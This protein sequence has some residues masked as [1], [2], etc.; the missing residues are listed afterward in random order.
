MGRRRNNPSKNE[1]QRRKREALQKALVHHATH[2]PTADTGA[3]LTEAIKG[4]EGLS[5]EK[6][7]IALLTLGAFD[8][9]SRPEETQEGP[10]TPAQSKIDKPSAEPDETKDIH[11]S[12][13]AK[14]LFERITPRSLFDRINP[15]T[16]N[17]RHHGSYN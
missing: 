17:N 4:I 5:P 16:I 8:K 2:K 12:P 6:K 11:R 9:L 14:S 7:A 13:P 15:E 10:A 1:R 3:Q